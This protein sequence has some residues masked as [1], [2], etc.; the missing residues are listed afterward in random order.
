M[1]LDETTRSQ[2]DSYLQSN[3][4]VL[5]MKGTRQFP[6]CGF[7]ATVAGILDR[8]V[9]D[10]KTVNVLEDESIRQ[11]I[12]EYANWPTIPQLYI[13]GE[14]IGG[15]DLVQEMF[16]SGE[17][18]GKLGVTIP[19]PEPPSIEVSDE[20]AELIREAM[21]G[22]PDHAL[23]MSVDARGNAGLQ[24]GPEPANAVRTENNGLVIFLDP[25][26]ASRADGLAVDLADTP[27]GQGLRVYRPDSDSGTSD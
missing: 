25:L 6:Q 14:F 10:Y 20:A 13:E 19:D 9:P 16:E 17:L 24:L 18:H 21:S 4:V 5:F 23:H 3:R 2:I 7:S 22:H 8:L 12:K 26:S 11:G 27:Q 1:A 15:C